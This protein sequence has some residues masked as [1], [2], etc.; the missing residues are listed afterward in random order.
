D[1][2]A[3]YSRCLPEVPSALAELQA[4]GMKLGIITNGS[5]H[6]QEEKIRQLGISNLMD[7]VLIS[8]REGLRKPDCKIF[9]RALQRLRVAPAEAWYVG[10][11]PL[12]DVHGAFEAGL[13]AVWRYTPQ[14]QRPEVPAH[15]IRG[16]DELVRI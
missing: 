16:L 10:D 7:E 15:E 4:G 12:V 2:Y 1:A 13:T 9:E 14:W 5:I 8:E 11:H 6:M 3:S